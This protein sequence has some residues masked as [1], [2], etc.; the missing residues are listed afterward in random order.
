[1]DGL[2][3]QDTFDIIIV[4]YIIKNIKYLIL[5][6]NLLSTLKIFLTNL[7]SII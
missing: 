7:S 2:F 5:I 6:I 1:M 4:K 3:E